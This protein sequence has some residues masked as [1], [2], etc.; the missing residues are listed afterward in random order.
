MREA[1]APARA[2][3][4][5]ALLTKLAAIPT[6]SYHAQN[7]DTMYGDGIGTIEFSYLSLYFPTWKSCKDHFDDSNNPASMCMK[8]ANDLRNTPTA[9]SSPSPSYGCKPMTGDADGDNSLLAVPPLTSETDA[10]LL[11]SG[12]TRFVSQ[13]INMWASNE[14]SKPGW[15]T[16]G[17]VPGNQIDSSF[18]CTAE[19]A[20]H[21]CASGLFAAQARELICNVKFL[22]T[23]PFSC[24]RL[25]NKYKT[26]EVISLAW[27]NVGLLWSTLLA[28]L[29]LV[30]RRLPGANTP[31]D[32]PTAGATVVTSGQKRVV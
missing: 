29:I 23:P 15:W 6:P 25:V 2:T 12:E 24:S 5:P 10:T 22:D 1:R 4:P 30:L 21:W 14:A 27:S 16:S 18:D 26:Q 28:I 20:K 11:S 17:T 13:G 3:L 19:F 8:I 7:G 31:S 9:Q 32:P